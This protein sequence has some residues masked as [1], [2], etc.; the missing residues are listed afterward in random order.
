MQ[1]HSTLKV[2]LVRKAREACS[3]KEKAELL[4][5]DLERLRVE[6]S[7]IEARYSILK[8]DYIKLCDDAISKIKTDLE[9]ELEGKT[10]EIEVF[11]P[12]TS[13]LKVLQSI[14]DKVADGIEL[15]L[16]KIGDGITFLPEKV[17]NML[18]AI[19]KAAN[20]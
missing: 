15:G 20:R 10:R 13:N 17:N 19:S 7:L 1:P 8:A 4:L 12:E 16:D 3:T 5:S 14:I 11:K 9:K 2:T 6:L 18:A